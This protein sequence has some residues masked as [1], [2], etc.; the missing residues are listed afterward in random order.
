MH[1]LRRVTWDL[2]LMAV[3][4]AVA[5]YGS[6]LGLLDVSCA[7]TREFYRDINAFA[8]GYSGSGTPFVGQS[9]TGQSSRGR[10]AC[11]SRIVSTSPDPRLHERRP[12]HE[13]A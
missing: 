1:A 7:P 6:P 11:S 13:H 10:H 2:P 9:A 3:V 5:G 12:S 8:Q 4:I